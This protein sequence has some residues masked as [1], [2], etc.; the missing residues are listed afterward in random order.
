MKRKSALLL[1]LP[2]LGALPATSQMSVPI[3]YSAEPVTLT[4]SVTMADG[5]T[6]AVTILLPP[7]AGAAHRVPAIMRYS[8]FAQPQVAGRIA[9]EDA[10]WVSHGYAR[11]LVDARGTG[12]SMG[13]TRYGAAELPDLRSLADWIVAQPWSDGRIGAA[14]ISFEG[15]AAELLAAVGRRSVRAV[16]LL[17]SDYGYYADLVRPGGIHLADLTASLQAFAVARETSQLVA[18]AIDPTDPSLAETSA[19]RHDNVDIHVASASAPFFDDPVP[20]TG[21]TWSELGLSPLAG[22]AQRQQTPMHVEVAWL[23]AGTA[24]GALERFSRLR[25]PQ[26]LTIGPWNHGGSRCEDQVKGIVNCPAASEARWMRLLAFFDAAL[27]LRAPGLGPRRVRY[28]T[29]GASWRETDRWPP[30]GISEAQVPLSET[31]GAFELPAAMTGLTNRWKTQVGGGPVS[32]A[33]VLPDLRRLPGFAA[34]LPRST[35]ITGQPRLNLRM[36]VSA[37]VNDPSLFAYLIAVLPDG[38][39][40]YLTEGQLRLINRRVAPGEI[41][42][43]D[44]RR[45]SVRPV[46]ADRT[47]RTIMTLLPMSV[48]LPAGSTLELRL[49]SGDRSSFEPT[50]TFSASIR[51]GSVLVLP[52]RQTPAR[53]VRSAIP[54]LQEIP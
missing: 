22:E 53:D 20:G 32:Y 37:G 16:A 40:A 9:E 50:P 46:H 38:R 8:R 49:A 45:G 48:V 28:Y 13:T 42:L 1:L 52:I 34:S 12:A 15:T 14:G 24:Q 11:V 44:Y 51:P 5:V 18:G 19:A 54:A 39:S 4:R 10:F 33:D 26:F 43:H 17:F 2:A 23:D 47:F 41:T 29:M 35:E 21:G 7:D 36:R 25:V 3:V 31:S 6:I 30:A 27:G